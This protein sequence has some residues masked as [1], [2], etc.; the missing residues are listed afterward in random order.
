M[1]QTTPPLRGFNSFL[2]RFLLDLKQWLLFMLYLS[3]FR[4][5]FIAFFNSKLERTSTVADIARTAV[6]GMRFD[7]AFTTYFMLLPFLMSILPRTLRLERAA[8]RARETFGL[9]FIF[10]TAI[11][12]IFTFVFFKEY[13]D[14]FN[15]YIFNLYYD[16]T[17]AILLTIWSDYHPV[18]IF[19]SISIASWSMIALRKKTLPLGDAPILRVASRTYPLFG[20]ITLSIACLLLIIF[21]SRGSFGDRPVQ[22]KDIGVASDP[23]LN[24]AVLNPYFSL[25]YAIQNHRVQTSSA[26]LNVFLPDGNIRRA[27]QELFHT[28]LESNDLDAYLARQAKGPKARPPRHIFLVLMESYDAWPFL[29]RYA[30]LGLT[31][32]LSQ[33]GK[34][35][36]LVDRFLP[37]SWGTSEAFSVLMT[38]LPYPDVEVNYQSTARTAYPSSIFETFKRLGYRTR[39]FYGGYLTWQRFGDFVRDQGAEEIY[40]AP[41]MNQGRTTHEW[42]V[43]DEYLLD[44]VKSKVSDDQPSF[45]F[46]LTTSYHPPFNVD[47]FT[48]GFPHR[49]MPADLASSY[50]GVVSL[51]VL[52]HLWYQDKCL[53]TFTR[54]MEKKLT[55]PVFAF[56]GDHYSRRFINAS[57]NYYEQSSVPFI[58]YGKDVLKGLRVPKDIAGSQ[59][60]IGPTLIELAAPAGFTYYAVGK[61]MLAGD[62]DHVGIGWWRMIGKD[63]LFD[64]GAQKF[65]PLPGQE[66]PK[67]LPDIASLK[68]VFNGVH[69]VGWW[70]IK[71]GSALP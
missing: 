71:K 62:R 4:I 5:A 11:A 58:L 51:K 50:D 60:D 61:D 1:E 38:G 70:R 57:P 43:D 19:V 37:S 32:E 53:G 35:G 34:E 9:V 33:L 68:K 27:A 42:G 54:S 52:G 64:V 13:N 3:A 14:Q 25:L 24:K 2:Q 21:A 10:L 48:A 15:H 63:Y 40:G 47:V 69:G 44:F 17:K 46:I 49:E 28:Q 6:N 65:H 56:T 59:L 18:L 23:F 29:P 30:S 12:W 31:H 16:D 66:L 8:D 7:S 45:N 39:L 36:I 22:P 55:R 41:H 20:R 26:G 67:E